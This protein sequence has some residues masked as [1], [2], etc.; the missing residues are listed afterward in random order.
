MVIVELSS[1]NWFGV[2]IVYPTLKINNS[3]ETICAARLIIE[4]EYPYV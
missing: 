2:W 1:D 4:S 3:H